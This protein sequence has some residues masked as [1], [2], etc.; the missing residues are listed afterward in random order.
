MEATVTL[1]GLVVL[2]SGTVAE[3]HIPLEGKCVQ[4]TLAF[5][6]LTKVPLE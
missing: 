6:F 2:I 1:L 3:F 4:G 5:P